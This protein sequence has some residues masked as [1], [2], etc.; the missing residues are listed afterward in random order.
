MAPLGAKRYTVDK[1]LVRVNGVNILESD[2]KKK[3]LG[4]EPYTLEQA[5]DAELFFQEAVKKKTVPT[6]VEVDKYIASLKAGGMSDDAF[7][8]Q[9]AHEG[10]TVKGYKDEL[11]RYMAINNVKHQIIRDRTF[12]TNQEIAAYHEQHPEW[13]E[14]EYLFKTAVIPLTTVDNE[15]EAA[16][17]EGLDWVES[18]WVAASD[19]AEEM[20]FVFTMK[21]GEISDPIK[22][23]FGYQRVQLV[24]RKEKRL[25]S[26][27]ERRASIEQII[28]QAK[29]AKIEDELLADMRK[30]A[31]IVRL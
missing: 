23:D 13:N 2:T 6:L 1:I 5:I 8:K 18:D 26:L 9:L 15:Q 19:V 7:A 16:A 28:K 14:P 27:E 29:M 31:L 12:V 22:T 20:H 25:Q 4:S 3:R 30:R 10:F 24:D 11:Y 21:I 17:V